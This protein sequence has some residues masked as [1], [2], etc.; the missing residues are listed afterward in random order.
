MKKP[1]FNPFAPGRSALVLS[2]A[3]SLLPAIATVKGQDINE[4]QAGDNF[5]TAVNWSLGAAPTSNAGTGS[6]K[7]FLF[8]TSS[9]TL[10]HSGTIIYGRSYNV[11]NGT[12]YTILS[13]RVTDP[14]TA[15]VFRIGS[16]SSTAPISTEFTN[17]VSNTLNDLIV[18]SNN[19]NLFFD[20]VN[21]VEGGLTPNLELR[22]TTGNFNISEGSTLNIGM[23]IT[24]NGA[25]VING[26]GATIL[27]GDR[28]GSGTTTVN[29]GS[30]EIAG[31]HSGTGAFN[32]FN[33]SVLISGS[34]AGGGTNVRNGTFEIT[35]TNG[36][37]G[38]TINNTVN[39]PA[40]TAPELKLGNVSALPA[41]AQITGSD[42]SARAGSVNL[43]VAGSYTMGS[44]VKGNITYAN[45]S[46]GQA[47]V[48]FTNP[49]GITTGTDGGRT[50]TNAGPDLDIVFA[51][52]L[53][54]GSATNGNVN[55]NTTGKITVAGGIVGT[56]A[57]RDLSK[58]SGGTLAVNG[59][60]TYTGSTRLN[61]GVLLLGNANAIPGGIGATG[62]ASN[63]FFNSTAAVI[64][65]TPASG[66]FLRTVGTGPDQVTANPTADSALV[67]SMGFAAFGGDRL[68][69]VGAPISLSMASL[70]G[71]G[72][73]LGAPSAD[74]KVTVV[75]DIALN[76]APRTFLVNNG[77]ADVD[78]EISGVISSPGATLVKTG[79]GTLALTGENTYASTGGGTEVRA[80]VLMVNGTSLSD[81]SKL[82]IDGGVVH[83]SGTEIVGSL[84]FGTEE[85][86]AGTWGSS[87]SSA[88]LAFQDDT[89]FSGP[90]VVVV[91]GSS[92]SGFESWATTNSATG[93]SLADDHDNDGV[94]NGIEYFLGGPSGNTTGFTPLPGVSQTAGTL[95]ITWTKGSGYTG[96]YGTHFWVET[97][98]TLTGTWTPETIPG[99]NI[100]DEPGFVKYTFPSPLSTKKFTRL[101][102]TGP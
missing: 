102:V 29:G 21:P 51:S 37:T 17:E 58:G 38:Y 48:T 41:G 93:Q 24:G 68:V 89:R 55:I 78:A 45:S 26:N 94:T 6:H 88:E 70:A 12:S 69:D 11:T 43:A 22:L 33:G 65:L 8:T 60:S 13:N 67:R 1:A 83:V 77:S 16:I 15:T 99:G 2:I 32:L 73:T 86:A 50:F 98:E 64:G 72:L 25:I 27:S 57:T 9:T 75:N 81:T 28:S 4:F 10:T 80:G 18:L 63:L 42:S 56:G 61:G 97:S 87:L 90:G 46:G 34:R 35:G 7:D 30:L 96:T 14:P 100:T 59:P 54:I 82:V 76:N 95:G 79:A 20:G 52:T 47:T 19:S 31:T 44:H 74:S 40:G 5:G 91:G 53:D 23:N 3:F 66:D 62:G 49:S 101:K 92:G 39:N 36:G 84:F 85:Q 71:R